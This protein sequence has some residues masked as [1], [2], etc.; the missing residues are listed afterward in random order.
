MRLKKI[1]YNYYINGFRWVQMG[2]HDV[3]G[4]IDAQ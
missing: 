2:A 4:C 3:Y 1:I